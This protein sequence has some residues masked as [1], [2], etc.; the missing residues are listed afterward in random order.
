[1]F[2]PLL[3]PEA[4]IDV[5]TIW[6]VIQAHTWNLQ[7]CLFPQR[8]ETEQACEGDARGAGAASGSPVPDVWRART[9]H[10]PPSPNGSVCAVKVDENGPDRFVVVV[11]PNRDIPASLLF[12]SRARK[13][14]KKA[15]A[16]RPPRAA[17]YLPEVT[18]LI[19]ISGF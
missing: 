11:P 9:C 16:A 15:A 4:R 14:E 7:T 19:N 12:P 5:A 2:P 6:R 8:R 13:Q 18:R 3:Q 17:P 10:V 1:M